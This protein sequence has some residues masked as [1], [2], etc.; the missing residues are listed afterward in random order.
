MTKHISR[1]KMKKRKI[2]LTHHEIKW[3]LFILTAILLATYLFKKDKNLLN[4]MLFPK[5]PQ[6][7][8]LSSKLFSV[9]SEQQ[10]EELR[11]EVKNL[12]KSVEAKNFELEQLI[13]E[14]KKRDVLLGT[15]F[16]ENFCIIKNK[17]NPKDILFLNP[18]WTIDRMPKYIKIPDREVVEKFL[19]EE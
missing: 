16:N 1:P 15:I 11:D 10:I 14:L 9:A 17:N 19:K 13:G 12:Q 18:N 7:S 8:D 3:V 2:N 5:K 6:Q 4:D